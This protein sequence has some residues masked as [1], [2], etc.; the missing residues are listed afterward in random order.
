MLMFVDCSP[1]TVNILRCPACCR[2]SKTRITF[3][4]FSSIFEAFVPHFYLCCT[5]CIIPDSLLNH[6]NSFCAGMLKLNANF[7]ADSLL[8]SLSH[9][10]CDGHTVHMLAQQCLPPAL[11]S[12]VKLA[13]FTHAHSSNLAAR[14]H[15]CCA[16]HSRYI[17]NGWSFSRPHIIIVLSRLISVSL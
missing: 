15:Q 4:R 10:E 12:P 7:D 8:Y 16:T 3:N 2:P 9:F 11:T 6:P 13:L 17:N 14:L 1:D 5:H